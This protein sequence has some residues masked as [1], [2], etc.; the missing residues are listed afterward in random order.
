MTTGS[1]INQARQRRLLTGLIT[2]IPNHVLPLDK[3]LD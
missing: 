3:Y 2:A 1:K